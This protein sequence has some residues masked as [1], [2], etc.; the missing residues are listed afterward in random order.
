MKHSIP[1]PPPAGAVPGA[2]QAATAHL[3]DG[4]IKPGMPAQ[5]ETDLESPGGVI[6]PVTHTCLFIS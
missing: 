1:A 2:E 6:H 5:L 4:Y 3:L